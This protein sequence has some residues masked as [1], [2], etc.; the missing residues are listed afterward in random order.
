[1]FCPAA[2]T[3]NDDIGA[4]SFPGFFKNLWFLAFAVAGGELIIIIIVIKVMMIISIIILIII[5]KP[6]TY[7][8]GGNC[9]HNTNTPLT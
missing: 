4:T 7:L 3:G 2:G 6:K 8:I 1:M 9:Q 5:M